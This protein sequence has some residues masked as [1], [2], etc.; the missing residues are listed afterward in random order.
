MHLQRSSKEV[1][2]AELFRNKMDHVQQWM[3]RIKLPRELRNKIRSYYSEVILVATV[4]IDIIICL[5]CIPIKSFSKVCLVSTACSTQTYDHY[6]VAVVSFAVKSCP[7]AVYSCAGLNSCCV[8]LCMHCC[9]TLWLTC[10]TAKC[11]QSI[12]SAAC[13]CHA[14]HALSVHFHNL[15]Q[16]CQSRPDTIT[17]S[18]DTLLS[19]R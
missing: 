5:F 3:A 11:V 13:C 7:H 8:G 17:H 10:F 14:C 2:E 6:C 19:V 12:C 4:L 18:A 15:S 1:Q 16:P 9:T